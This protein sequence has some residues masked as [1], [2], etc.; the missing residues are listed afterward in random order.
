MGTSG[1]AAGCPP[2]TTRR[3]RLLRDVAPWQDAAMTEQAEH[4]DRISEG[5]ARWWAPVIAPAAVA[6]LDEVAAAIDGGATQFNIN[7][8]NSFH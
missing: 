6:A 2:E 8:G 5:Y 3:R 4:Y 7:A 1:R